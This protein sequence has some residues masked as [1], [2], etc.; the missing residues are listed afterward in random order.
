MEERPAVP[1]PH[2]SVGKGKRLSIGEGEIPPRF[3]ST[4]G[5]GRTIGPDEAFAFE[6]ELLASK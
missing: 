3:L 4:Q 5:A 2:G 1:H 6:V